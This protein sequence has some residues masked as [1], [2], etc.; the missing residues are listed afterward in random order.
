MP[1]VREQRGQQKAGVDDAKDVEAV[2]TESV[3]VWWTVSHSYH[4]AM[5]SLA[6]SCCGRWRTGRD[7]DKTHLTQAAG[8]SCSSEFDSPESQRSPRS[9][10]AR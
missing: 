7:P 9:S 8:C 4:G 2:D 6:D 1:V 10:G 3:S 5:V